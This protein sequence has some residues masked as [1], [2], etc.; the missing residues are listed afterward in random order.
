MADRNLFAPFFVIPGFS[1]FGV[2]VHRP[3]QLLVL[4]AMPSAAAVG[5]FELPT[6]ILSALANRRGWSKG[7][8]R[9]VAI[10]AP[11][12]ITLLLGADVWAFGDRVAGGDRL[13]YGPSLPYA[14]SMQDLWQRHPGDGCSDTPDLRALCS[15]TELKASFSIAQLVGACRTEMGRPTEAPVCRGM[16]LDDP[17]AMSWDGD[18]VLIAQ[19]A[20]WCASRSDPVC[21]ARYLPVAQQVFDLTQWRPPSI[22]CGL[23][24]PKNTQYLAALGATFPIPPDRVVL[25]SNIGPLDMAFHDLVG[26][27]ITHS[28][29]DQ[30]LPSRE[31]SSWL[32][33]S[34]LQHAG[35]TT[36]AEL[37][38]SLGIDGVVLS[39][40]QAGLA[41]DYRALGWTQVND[42]PVAFVNPSPSGLAAEWTG[43][44]SVLVVGATQVSVPELYNSVFKRATTG[45]LPFAT[46]W[47]VRDTSPYI[48]D[49][50]PA[51]LSRYSGL[52]LLGYRYHDQAR[53]WALLDGYVR[54]GGSLF[55]ET[56]WQFVDPDWDSQAAP[57]PLPVK[58]VSWGQLNS[59]L[60]VTI[61]GS[62]DTQFGSF[63]YQGGGWGASS[64]T[65]LKPGATE[66][67]RVGD[68][69]ASARWQLGRGKVV[70][71]GMNLIAHDAAAGSTDEDQFLAAQFSWLFP[72]AGPQQSIA[73]QWTG[74][75]VVR[76]ALTQSS[77][78]TLVLF[79]ESLFPGWSAQLETPS[80]SRPVPLVGSEM[81]FAL[82]MLDSVPP[83][84]VLVFHYGPT[85]A[86]YL[87]WA[88]S[89]ATLVLLIGWMLKPRPFA[90]GW[91]RLSKNL[92]QWSGAVRAPFKWEREDK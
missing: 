51:E 34:M 38:A 15:N 21:D 16:Q 76:L 81:D 92:A 47:L 37:A 27:G 65:E 22:E 66:L 67:V 54:G 4:V 82:A 23:T 46:G 26:G 39:P 1:E 56:G 3:F 9:G 60:P 72:P 71:S 79:K 19:T 36:K 53:A 29:N 84:A 48:D 35:T 11:L 44:T 8:R 50:S 33:D 49:L 12:A 75:D 17:A 31:L 20:G 14:S 5:L 7:A 69:I 68:R 74:G 10:A 64:A 58:S 61:D 28:Y 59:S 88:V 57:Y 91:N 89:G 2:V 86:V 62:L 25:N 24:C 90:L 73:P 40:Q 83:G 42:Q 77:L 87:S 78:P 63:E 13:A 52:I 43:G 55:V 30:V 80:G 70:W 41:A 45:M 18:A 6:R 85:G 32:E